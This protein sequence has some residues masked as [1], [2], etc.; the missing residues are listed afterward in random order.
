MT[1]ESEKRIFQADNPI[2][3]CHS[4]G[5]REMKIFYEVEGV[6]VHS[7]VL[8]PS[9]ESAIEFPRGDIRLGYCGACGF[10]ENVSFDPGLLDYTQDYEETQGF[11]PTFN[12]FARS[13]AERL[14][15]RYDL[16][17]K[18]VLEIGC[19]KGEFLVLL[20]ELGN[21]QGVGIDPAYVPERTTSEVAKHITFIQDF[22]SE[23]Y[24][25]ITAD[26]VCCRHTLE[27]IQPTR[28]F[29]WMVRHAVKGRGDA[30]VFFEVPDVSRVLRELA[31]WDIYYEHCSYFSMGSLARLFRSCGFEVLHLAKDFDD[32]YLVI[33]AKLGGRAVGQPL[34]GED[35]LGEL[36]RQVEYFAMNYKSKLEQWRSEVGD[37][38][39]Q[40]RRCVLWSA[41]SKGVAFL[42][43]L[44]ID[45]EIEFAV[46]MN[47]FKHGKY[48]PGTGQE[49]VPPE[50]LKEYRPDMVL[51]MNPI[52]RLE[53]QGMLDQMHVAADVWTL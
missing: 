6:P 1:H 38:V 26:F 43:T 35:D 13:L 40:G 51:L 3:A 46:D 48:M 31:F 25:H 14:I 12:R 2:D 24:H 29:L 42:T 10:I 16:R 11:S 22:Y 36:T 39:D 19:G 17:G 45:E 50:F 30:V 37:V 23:A 5:A 47:P 49:I 27:H 28:D 9:R 4:C 52:Y 15:D 32:Q 53:V 18:E 20:C 33:D 7:V 21:N 34:P 8:V 44:G 41:S